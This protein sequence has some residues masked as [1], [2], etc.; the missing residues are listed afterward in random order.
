MATDKIKV[1]VRVR[2]FNRRGTYLV[3][4]EAAGYVAPR[5]ALSGAWLRPAPPRLASLWPPPRATRSISGIEEVQRETL[6]GKMQLILGFVWRNP[7]LPRELGAPWLDPLDPCCHSLVI[8]FYQVAPTVSGDGDDD[9]ANHE[10]SLSPSRKMI[11]DVYQM[12]A[13]SSPRPLAYDTDSCS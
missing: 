4:L 7:R 2:P 6:Y 1:A 13:D 8:V 3:A 10:S 9:V 12:L 11:L 5:F